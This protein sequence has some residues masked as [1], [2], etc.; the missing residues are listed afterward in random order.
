MIAGL[1]SVAELK[2]LLTAKDA[3]LRDVQV[4]YDGF[5]STWYLKDPAAQSAWAA[6]WQRLISA[7]GAARSQAETA[8]ISADFEPLPDKDLPAQAQYQEILDALQPIAHQVT[9]GDFQDLYNRLSAAVGAPIPEPG[10]K[11][12]SR[13]NDQDLT[14]YQSADAAIRS[15]ESASSILGPI[16]AVTLVSLLAIG[17]TSY[18]FRAAK[19]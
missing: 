5:A 15:V 1:W 11:Q 2:D 14:W 18:A 13:G 9:P 17:A 3:D 4:A 16:V 6:D 10:I 7:Y 12:P 19:G 8:I